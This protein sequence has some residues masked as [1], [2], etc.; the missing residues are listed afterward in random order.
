MFA[1]IKNI[2]VLYA[3]VT[4]KYF[5]SPLE[6][7]RFL[8]NLQGNIYHYYSSITF[9]VLCISRC[10]IVG[11]QSIKKRKHQL[12]STLSNIDENYKW[13]HTRHTIMYNLMWF[14]LLLILNS[15][16]MLTWTKGVFRVCYCY[17]HLY[18]TIVAL[19]CS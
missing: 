1:I 4:N 15:L 10:Y 8:I 9:L 14:N 16:V 12:E 7:R 13:P 5:Y 17:M 2:I 6:Q 18:S 11:R 19:L 3:F